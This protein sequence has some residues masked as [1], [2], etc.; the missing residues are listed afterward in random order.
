MNKHNKGYS[1]NTVAGIDLWVEARQ[2]MGEPAD[3]TEASITKSKFSEHKSNLN[4]GTNHS[5][6]CL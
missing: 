6:P 2:L 1:I 4:L 3:P 5:P